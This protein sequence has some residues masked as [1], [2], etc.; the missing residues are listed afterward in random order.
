MSD[1][2]DSDSSRHWGDDASSNMTVPLN[3]TFIPCDL[4]THEAAE[5]LVEFS[6]SSRRTPFGASWP[7][8][9]SPWLDGEY[10][11]Y[12]GDIQGYSQS[13]DEGEEEDDEED[14]DYDSYGGGSDTYTVQE[15]EYEEQDT[16]EWEQDWS[17][18]DELQ[19]LVDHLHQQP[20]RPLLP[21]YILRDPF[22]HT[23]RIL[24]DLFILL[25]RAKHSAPRLGMKFLD[26]L[27]DKWYREVGAG[28]LSK[29]WV[30]S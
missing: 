14:Q 15:E 21:Q 19:D 10:G 9:Y 13:D 7:P 24:V 12:D 1:Y 30:S 8:R 26:K 16:E 5:A 27:V 18:D 25:L 22:R 4:H 23:E 29:Y 20:V 17:D 11:D 3:P 6:H 2:S 28:E